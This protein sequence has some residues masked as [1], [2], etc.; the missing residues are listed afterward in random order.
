M[1][2]DRIGAKKAVRT[3]L[4]RYGK[5]FYKEMGSKGGSSHDGQKSAETMKREYGENYFQELGRIGGKRSKKKK[6]IIEK[7]IERF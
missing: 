1:S 6:T 5:D 7:I 3:T 4:R 2:G